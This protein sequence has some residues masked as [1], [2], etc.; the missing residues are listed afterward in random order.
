[1][2]KRYYLI[3][4]KFFSFGANNKKLLFHLFFSAFLRSLSLLL[5]PFTASM[6]VKYA[7]I[8]YIDSYISYK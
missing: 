7:A 1:M 2:F 3:V 8:S 6:I 4:K 5:I